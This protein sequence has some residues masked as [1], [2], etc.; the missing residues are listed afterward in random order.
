MS[1]LETFDVTLVTETDRAWVVSLDGAGTIALPKSEVVG[2]DIDD[3]E[4]GEGCSVEIPTWLAEHR[5][6]VGAPQVKPARSSVD[7]RACTMS[8]DGFETRE[9]GGETFLVMQLSASLSDAGALGAGGH[10]V[11]TFARS[12]GEGTKVRLTIEVTA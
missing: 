3:C 2:G 9:R 7:S 8:V 10:P 4:P 12:L 5:G 11:V 6:M 1:G